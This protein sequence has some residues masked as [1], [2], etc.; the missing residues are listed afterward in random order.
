GNGYCLPAGPLREGI[1]R[2]STV[3]CLVATGIAAENEYCQTYQLGNLININNPFHEV[4]INA[5]G[6]MVHAV[7]GIGNPRPFYDQLKALGFLVLEHRFADHR[8]FTAEDLHFHD[9]LPVIMT[10]KDAVKCRN[11]AADNWWFMPVSS[12]LP[13]E[14]FTNLTKMLSVARQD[15]RFR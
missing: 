1:A 6:K 8:L 9:D 7:A 13:E 10:E 11:F 2:A 5:M 14:F 3:D 12:H 4:E 15:V